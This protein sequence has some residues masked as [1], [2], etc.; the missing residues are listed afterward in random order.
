LI[1]IIVI[2]NF[3]THHHEMDKIQENGEQSFISGKRLDVNWIT[4]SVY[5]FLVLF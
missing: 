4:Y 2:S 5:S 1:K 3:E